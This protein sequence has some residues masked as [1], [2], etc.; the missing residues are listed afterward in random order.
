M[1]I[2]YLHQRL[3]SNGQLTGHLQWRATSKGT[4]VMFVRSTLDASISQLVTEAHRVALMRTEISTQLSFKHRFVHFFYHTFLSKVM[5][6][7]TSTFI[8]R[9]TGYRI[10]VE[11]KSHKSKRCLRFRRG[12]DT[13]AVLSE[14]VG[15]VRAHQCQCRMQ[16]HEVN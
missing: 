12:K 2:L 1:P 9:V 14:T 8:L 5:R 3:S 13:F 15:N 4:A 16:R 11:S 10:E 7:L 6:Y